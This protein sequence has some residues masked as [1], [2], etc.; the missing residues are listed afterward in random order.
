MNHDSYDDNYILDILKNIKTVAVV[1]ASANPVRPSHL[2]T[3]YLVSK[4][5][6][7]IPVNP[8]QAGRSIAGVK[9]VRK[10]GDI[11]RPVDM[12][13]IFRQSNAMPDVVSQAIGMDP[14]P[15][16]IWMQLGLRNDR[17]A[18]MAEASGIRVV[19]NRCTKIE[20]ARLCGEIVWAGVSSGLV[21]SRK[22]RLAKGYQHFEIGKGD[23]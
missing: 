19:M 17:A 1:G 9:A 10:L 13:D 11:G 7:V 4:G 14:P 20:Y 23:G 16:V 18:A 6:D 12:V 5:F 22:P 8:G 2:V 15:K 3:K 21:S